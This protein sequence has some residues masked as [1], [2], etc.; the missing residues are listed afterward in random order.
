MI[1][2]KVCMVGVAGVGK[3]S[4]VQQFV[5]SLFSE[6]YHSTVGVKIDRK[7][8]EVDGAPVNLLLW[9]IEGRTPEQELTAAYI[10]GAHG[11][12][13]VTDGTRRET[14]DQLRDIEELV[15]STVGEVPSLVALNKTDLTDRWMLTKH[16]ET[17]LEERGMHRVRT[18]AKSGDGVEDAFRWLA[19][20]TLRAGA[21]RQ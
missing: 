20:A 9:D 2:K 14:F 21:K 5:H 16:D 3:T 17:L 19:D 13:Y 6:K 11:V 18:S 12:L 7:I 1:Q 8:V 10:R 4:L 15:R